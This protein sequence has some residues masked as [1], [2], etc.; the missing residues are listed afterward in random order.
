MR[1]MKL[2]LRFE[3]LAA[4]AG[5][6]SRP[7]QPSLPRRRGQVRKLAWHT[8]R[9]RSGDE[10]RKPPETVKHGADA[11]AGTSPAPVPL[12]PSKAA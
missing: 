3:L 9:S 7:R 8:S 4:Q 1:V 12:L 5:S 11:H 2:T 10:D 6:M